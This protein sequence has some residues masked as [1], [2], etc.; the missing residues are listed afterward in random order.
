MA[1]RFPAGV[2]PRGRPE[3]LTT[4]TQRA[5]RRTEV[6]GS[7][8]LS[9]PLGVLCVSVVDSFVHP[10]RIPQQSERR[11]VPASGD[12]E[13]CPKRFEICHR[14]PG[15]PET[16]PQRH[17]EHRGG[18]RSPHQRLSPCPSVSSVSLWLILSSTQRGSLTQSERGCGGA[19]EGRG[20]S[21]PALQA[22]R[23]R[24]LLPRRRCPTWR[25]CRGA[26]SF[27]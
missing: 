13:H 1:L 10:E 17:R 20:S 8:T 2:V 23:S 19:R 21:P 3:T 18:R 9:V 7:T 27:R 15:R 16:S 14:K 24:P 25:G 11:K 22:I 6:T 26:S 5:Q 12:R 4:E